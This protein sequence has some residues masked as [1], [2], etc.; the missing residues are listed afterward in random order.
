MTQI[1]AINW[2]TTY[3]DANIDPV[4]SPD[5]LVQLVNRYKIAN[6]W[7]AST[8]I[9]GNYRIKVTTNN[10]LYRCI[11]SGTTGA[12]EPSWPTLRASRVGYVVTDNTCY[13]QDEGDAPTDNYDLS[14][15]AK[16]AWTLKALK[17]VN[18][19]NTSDEWLQLE[20]QQRHAHCVRMANSFMDMWVP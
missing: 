20:L 1:E 8:A 11:E 7:V 19:I 15:L 16:A 3:A 6:D 9:T 13:W 2:L 5:E 18:D 10:R 4:L 17:C 12:D 14:G